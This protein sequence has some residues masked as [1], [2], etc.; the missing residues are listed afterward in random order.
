MQFSNQALADGQRR[1]D[2]SSAFSEADLPARRACVFTAVMAA[3]RVEVLSK[4]AAAHLRGQHHEKEQRESRMTPI[5]AT[6]RGKGH[7]DGTTKK[8]NGRGA[9]Y[10]LATRAARPLASKED[11]VRDEV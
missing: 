1:P 4:R 6:R 2:R 10:L 9:L 7:I 5:D 3:G 8:Y 11:R